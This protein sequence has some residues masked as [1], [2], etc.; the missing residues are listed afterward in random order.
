MRQTEA[1]HCRALS[2]SVLCA[3]YR[4]G[5]CMCRAGVALAF[6]F[7]SVFFFV[8]HSHSPTPQAG[9]GR[10]Q[11][12]DRVLLVLP[13][14]CLPYYDS[15]FEGAGSPF[16]LRAHER[17]ATP[18]LAPASDALCLISALLVHLADKDSAVRR[19]FAAIGGGDAGAARVGGDAVQMHLSHRRAG[20]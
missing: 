18:D 2:R 1:F 12:P 5:M 4:C 8:S 3:V 15:G 17:G 11:L 19:P 16:E 6:Q 9:D 10:C 14:Y 20:E 7:C 13:G